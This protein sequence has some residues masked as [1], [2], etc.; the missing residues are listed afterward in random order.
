MESIIEDKKK[1][2]KKLLQ[3]TS[4]PEFKHNMKGMRKKWKNERMKE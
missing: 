3:K 1:K 4:H 2:N